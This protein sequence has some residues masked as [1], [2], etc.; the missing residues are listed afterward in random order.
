[1]SL[2][3][4]KLEKQGKIKN[5]SDVFIGSR[6]NSQN[7]LRPPKFFSECSFSEE[8]YASVLILKNSV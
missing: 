5:E 7:N 3:D 6:S 1:V 2:L 8:N 4:S